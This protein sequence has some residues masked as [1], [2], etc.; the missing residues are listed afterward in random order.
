MPRAGTRWR[1]L[2]WTYA[3]LKPIT[4]YFNIDVHARPHLIMLINSSVYSFSCPSSSQDGTSSDPHG[5][6]ASVH[7]PVSPGDV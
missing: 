5:H 1:L 2:I 6:P 4:V 3:C 7:K